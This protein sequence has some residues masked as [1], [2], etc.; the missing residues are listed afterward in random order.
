[1]FEVIIMLKEDYSQDTRRKLNVHKTF[2]RHLLKLTFCRNRF[3]RILLIFWYWQ[4]FYGIDRH[5]G[6]LN[7]AFQESA[8]IKARLLPFNVRGIWNILIY[9]QSVILNVFWKVTSWQ[10]FQLEP[11]ENLFVRTF[12][13]QY[14]TYFKLISLP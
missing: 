12:S 14:I 4:I 1:M 3:Q 11:E 7:P 13:G 2:R 6:F 5:L 9:F 10:K 8:P